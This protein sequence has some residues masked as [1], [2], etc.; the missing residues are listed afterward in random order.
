ML[1]PGTV[2]ATFEEAFDNLA[3]IMV[4]GIV[5]ILITLLPYPILAFW[6]A[7]QS[8]K[9]SARAVMAAWQEFIV[10][11]YEE[12]RSGSFKQ[13]RLLKELL[14]LDRNVKEL[15]AHLCDSYWECCAF[16]RWSRWRLM[17]QRL[18]RSFREIY[19]R[20]FTA[21]AACLSH[22]SNQE[23]AQELRAHAELAMLLSCKLLFALTD[24]ADARNLESLDGR[25][26][27]TPCNTSKE[28]ATTSSNKKEKCIGMSGKPI[29]N[30]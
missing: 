11:F 15:E 1:T 5:A 13:D 4:G 20:L 14:V 18:K 23:V 9:A 3:A 17:L 12:G 2:E 27:H 26:L 8:S 29:R 25:N 24:A 7:H 6:N 19:D 22:Q 21:Q 10:C 30:H 28:K 16:A